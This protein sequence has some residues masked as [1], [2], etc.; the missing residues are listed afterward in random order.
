VSEAPTDGRPAK[1]VFALCAGMAVIG[2]API[3]VRWAA[4]AP[5]MAVVAWRTAVAAAVIV[6][7]TL[8][9]AGPAVRALSGRDWL[10]SSVA[11]V[12]L[13]LHF[14]AWTISIYHTSVASA[15]V[16]VTSSPLFIAVLGW[17]VLRDRLSPRTI[18]AIGAGMLGAAM[19]ALA[20]TTAGNFPRAAYGNALALSAAL[21]VAVYLLIGR[22]IR[23][24]VD[25]LAYLLPA[26][27]AAA[28]T[29]WIAAAIDGTPL[30]QPLYIIGL[31]ALLALGPQLVGHSAFN[32][33]IRFVPAALVG[34][35]TLAEPVVGTLLAFLIFAETPPPLA[36]MGGVV[37]LAAIAISLGPVRERGR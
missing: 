26:Y 30:M 16:L 4:E 19:I 2:F 24:R 14:S 1:V 29:T 32:Y 13:G 20:D 28:A 21:L 31:S 35:A 37:V 33:A 36:L 34:L 25:L 8:M 9:R 27:L 5:P 10:L 6:P 12:F 17:I 22:A 3:L 18:G 23:Q 15:S 7:L 11:G